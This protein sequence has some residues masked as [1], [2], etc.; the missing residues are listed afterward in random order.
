MGIYVDYTLRAEGDEESVRVR[1]EAVRRRC[2]DLPLRAVGDVQRVSPV[3]NPIVI[4]LLQ[5][6]GHKL[7]E[8]IAR[9]VEEAERDRDHGMRCITFAPMLGPTLPKEEID[10]YH[11]S[12][13]EFIQQTDLWRPNDLPDSIGESAAGFQVLTVYRR[14]I[15]YEFASIMLRYGYMLILHPGEGSESVNL[16][17][18]TFQP[19]GTR[20]SSG[21]PPLWWG[22]S[23]T[24]T[25]YAKNFI[26]AHET[27]CRVLD[28]VREEGLL[29]KASDN[30]GYY[31]GRKWEDA[32]KRVNEE[33]LFAGMMSGLI[34]GAIGDLRE[35]GIPVQ[36]I[37]DN[38][39][40]A[41]PVDFSAALA[42]EREQEKEK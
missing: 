3:Y 31:A 13:L 32:S 11:G 10:R 21:Q 20:S 16:A 40:Q 9:R 6:Q 27:V 24:K 18:S 26:Q 36:V 42:R 23:F 5:S 1:L 17:L 19:S 41:R 12:V 14:G 2:L 38:A 35:E 29:L 30:C 28:I 25:Q 37:E 8:A 39:S 34:G 4:H 33:L 15:E 7:P 22:Q